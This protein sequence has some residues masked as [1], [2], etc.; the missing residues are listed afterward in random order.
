MPTNSLTLTIT[1]EV[2]IIIPWKLRQQVYLVTCPTFPPCSPESDGCSGV[3][4]A[5]QFTLISGLYTLIQIGSFWWCWWH[6]QMLQCVVIFCIYF[7][8]ILLPI[9]SNLLFGIFSNIL[10]QGFFLFFFMELI[11]FCCC[12]FPWRGRNIFCN[13]GRLLVEG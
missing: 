7:A 9:T 5:D 12:C 1:P 2:D 10:F 8:S 3:N 6:H 11:R 4:T 13:S